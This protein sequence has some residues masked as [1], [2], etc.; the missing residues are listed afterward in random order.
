MSRASTSRLIGRRNRAVRKLRL[1]AAGGIFASGRVEDTMVYAAGAADLPGLAMPE[2]DDRRSILVSSALSALLHLL[3]IGG[4]AY[5]GYLAQQ[6]VEQVIPVVIFNEPVELPGSND[7]SPLPVP[8]MLSAPIA[9]A[10]PLAM[11]PADLAAVPAPAVVAPKL[12]LTAPKSLD[13]AEMTS[14]P[15]ALQADISPTPSAADISEVQPLEVSAADLVAPKIDLTGPTHTADRTATDLAAPKAFESLSELNATQYK[16]AVSA[17]PTAGGGVAGAEPFAATGVSAE[18]LAAG[19]SGGDPSAMGT[20]PCLHSA[21]VVR[22]QDEMQRRM[23]AR[24]EVPI[25]SDP[26]DVVVI[27]M[28]VDYSG[29]IANLELVESTDPLFAESAMAALNDAAPFS[30]LNDNNR[31]LAEK[32]LKLRFTNPEQR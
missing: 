18:Y 2:P 4:I 9:S 27:K 17:V 14:A 8:K 23:E 11:Q 25:D 12:D 32:T 16:G 5:V 6:A 22:Y 30:P 1:G 13:L 7:P 19:F 21:F 26:D 24:W 10:I 31:C 20:V 29:Q 15:L 3:V 28:S